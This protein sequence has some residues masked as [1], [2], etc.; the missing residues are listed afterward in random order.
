MCV[1]FY[2]CFL[3][4]VNQHNTFSYCLS[5]LQIQLWVSSVQMN[6]YE[7]SQLKIQFG[8]TH[9]L[10]TKLTEQSKR[11]QY[12]NFN[13]I[14]VNPVPGGWAQ[15]RHKTSCDQTEINSMSIPP[16]PRHWPIHSLIFYSVSA[17]S[18]RKGPHTDCVALFLKNFPSLLT[19]LQLHWSIRGQ[20]PET[21]WSLKHHVI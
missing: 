20:M 16:L 14:T 19:P 1:C 2:F 15:A 17:L 18:A 21:A 6:Y 5:L 13:A 9:S 12:R 10:K 7:P 3:L 4:S 11:K 8:H